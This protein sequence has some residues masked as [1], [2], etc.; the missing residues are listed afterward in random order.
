MASFN[1]LPILCL[2]TILGIVC[3]VNLAQAK[4]FGQFRGREGEKGWFWY[5]VNK[6]PKT[7]NA[8]NSTPKKQAQM[9]SP[10]KKQKKDFEEEIIPW[11]E[12]WTMHPDKFQKT[13]NE[14]QKK[15]VQNPN[16][17]YVK[18]YYV[19]QYIAM[20]RAKQFQEKVTDV[21]QSLPSLSAG[22]S[23]TRVGSL[24]GSLKKKELKNEIIPF[25]RKKMGL[26]LFTSAGCA[27]C[28]KQKKI[29]K[30][31]EESW[32]WENIT[33]FDIGRRPELKQRF[34]IQIVPEIWVVGQVNNEI[35]QERLIAGLATTGDIE[36]ELIKIYY[37]WYRGERYEKPEVFQHLV[38]PK[39]YIDDYI[40]QRT[41]K[42]F[43]NSTGGADD[44]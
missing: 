15:A 17:H 40:K 12:V 34:E 21:A 5:E 27:Y 24:I 36:K 30:L 28:D 9:P 19:L 10:K 6:K 2:I 11:D 39:D 26:F 14:T 1:K 44:N 16:S 22:R 38:K 41:H 32:S 42:N 4:D 18:D 31:F 7:T 13:L 8:T 37:K 20:T 23:P 3:G 29:L 25:M 35:K 33:V 43:Q